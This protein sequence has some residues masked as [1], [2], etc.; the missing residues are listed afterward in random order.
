MRMNNKNILQFLCALF[1]IY[2]IIDI[3]LTYIGLNYIGLVEYNFILGEY[4]SPYFMLL[5]GVKMMFAGFV[6]Y[7]MIGFYENRK[8]HD[9]YKTYNNYPIVSMGVINIIYTGLI[10]NN[11]YW[12]GLI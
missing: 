10:I 4:V 1:I 3:G 11:L 7:Y 8:N 6:S 9:L 12:M 5:S 2:N